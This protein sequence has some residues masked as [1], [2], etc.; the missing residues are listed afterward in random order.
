MSLGDLGE[1]GLIRRIADNV[2][3]APGVALGIGD[4]CAALIPTPGRQLLTTSDMLVE[5]VHFDLA[6]SDP[7]TL[8]RKSLAVNLS[9]VAAMGGVP[10]WFLL[11]LA[12]PAE[13]QL[14][15]LDDFTRGIL[16]MAEEFGVT[17]VGGDTCA[18]K[19][20]LVISVTLMGEQ[21]PERVVTRG[22][23]KTGD[24]VC[25]SG[26]PG[27][28]ALGLVKLSRGERGE[29]TVRHLDPLPRI[30]AG[31]ALAEAGIPTAM[32][33]VSD[34][35]VADLG[36][37][38]EQSGISGARI[39]AALLPSSPLFKDEASRYGD[40]LAL[41]LSGGEDYELLFTLHPAKKELLPLLTERL[42]LPLTV[43]GEI[44]AG[45]GVRVAT[46]EGEHRPKASGY[47][48]FSGC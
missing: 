22:G 33:D 48:H 27:D 11:S 10:R 8:G 34:G 37:I 4:D 2:A 31:L 19:K 25:V 29:G 42:G 5:G 16:S 26:F 15:F 41:A 14:P 24:L 35:I 47:D 1:F 40:P 32:I 43:I 36:H 44:D 7:Y 28:S 20:G 30:A 9:D 17:L 46:A 12:L 18:S 23:A 45:T 3:A 39:D 38:L 13:L 6:W 21:L